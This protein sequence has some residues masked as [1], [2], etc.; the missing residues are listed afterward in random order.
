[1]FKLVQVLRV[2]GILEASHLGQ[3]LLTHVLSQLERFY[4]SLQSFFTA[5]FAKKKN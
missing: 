2:L 5:K 3:E 4:T 1:M